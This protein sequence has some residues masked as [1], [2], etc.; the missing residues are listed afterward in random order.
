VLPTPLE[1]EWLWAALEA[2]FERRGAEAFLHA[3]LVLP[4]DHFFPDRWSPDVDGVRALAERLLGYAG[5]GQLTVALELFTE[6]E[7]VE[8]FGPDGKPA[9]WSHTGAA[10][11]F[12]GIGGATC[13]FGVASGKL[14][15]PMGLVAAMAHEVAHAFRNLHR[16]EHRDR[17]HEE[18]LTDITTVY[19][20]FGVL[21]TA[22]SA[23][24]T[25]R[26]HDNLGSSWSHQ[27]Q[28]YLT[29][30]QMSFLLATQ[31]LIR[32][33]DVATTRAV[34]K[35]LPSNQAAMLR[36]ALREIDRDA[37]ANVLGLAD[38]PPA[39][40]PVPWWRRLFAG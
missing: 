25:T 10:A 11:W 6:D 40:P 23:R 2:L 26:S 4:T 17:D 33:A 36:T 8:E 16:L 13:Y 34:A 30:A 20:G 37:V 28:G 31:L 5:L 18:K 22:A 39:P 32:G 27:S 38:L 7:H 24:F 9:K 3:P 21:T 19:L 14:A 29:P 1:R 12:A 35:Q 15:D